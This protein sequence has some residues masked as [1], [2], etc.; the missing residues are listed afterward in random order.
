MEFN[1]FIVMKRGKYW[2]FE[3]KTNAEYFKIYQ[4]MWSS[5]VKYSWIKES[6]KYLEFK[7]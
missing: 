2:V 4:D 5:T 6:V 1:S 3:L 7:S